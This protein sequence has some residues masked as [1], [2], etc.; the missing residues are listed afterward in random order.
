MDI[1]GNDTDY[2]LQRSILKATSPTPLD[3]GQIP[4]A[5]PQEQT[6]MKS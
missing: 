4:A 6:S 3:K 1:F 2:K 5:Q